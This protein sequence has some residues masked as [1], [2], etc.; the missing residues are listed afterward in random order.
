MSQLFEK[1]QEFQVLGSKVTNRNE[2]CN[3]IRRI[4]N[5]GNAYFVILSHFQNA[6]DLEVC[7]KHGFY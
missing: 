7:I 4:I 6:S 3:E 1:I 2:V 5:S